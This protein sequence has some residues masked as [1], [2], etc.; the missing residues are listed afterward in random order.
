MFTMAVMSDAKISSNVLAFVS[1]VV[2]VFS[3]ALL[4]RVWDLQ[5]F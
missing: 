5:L 2:F 3:L 4:K 1:P